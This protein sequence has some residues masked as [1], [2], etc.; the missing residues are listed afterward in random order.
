MPDDC[1]D[2]AAPQP[3]SLGDATNKNKPERE[4]E[5]RP[6][7]ILSDWDPNESRRN[8]QLRGNLAFQKSQDR[9]YDCTACFASAGSRYVTLPPRSC[10]ACS[11]SRA[12]TLR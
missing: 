12:F 9:S 7:A 4:G 3:A 8:A 1:G 5:N 11:C 10:I 6:V 2:R